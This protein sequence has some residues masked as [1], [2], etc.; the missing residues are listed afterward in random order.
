MR[1]V[2]I[3]KP[4]GPEVLQVQELPMPVPKP[5]EVRV[6]VMA[7]AVNRLDLLQRMG[8]YPVPKDDPQDIPGVEY[9]GVVDALGDGVGDV[10]IG[11]RVFGLVG[12]G[13]YAEYLVVA[14][15]L[16]ARIP[17]GVSFEQAASMPEAFIT[18]YD[19]M[20]SQ[21]G[22]QAG[23][24][25]LISAVGSGV[26]TAAVQI[27]QALGAT[28]IGTARSASK[29][30]AAKQYG[31]GKGIVV[32]SGKFA[33][34]VLAATAG[35][36]V[37]VVLE[38]VGGDYV[39]EDIACLAYQGRLILVG[40]VAG[41]KTEVDLAMLLR[42]RLN[43]RGTVLRSRPTAEKLDVMQTFSREM[44]P[45]IAKGAVQPV[46]DCVFQLEQAAAAHEYMAANENF[47]KVVLKVT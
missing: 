27:A 12:G 29:L 15:N 11:E 40:L 22:L 45:L 4:G 41:G 17:V 34:A 13:A 39:A 8:K 23:E 2:V 26:G 16:I 5:G 47:G 21:G 25:V 31:L 30:E 28:N 1:A 9:A 32:E 42:K 7:T 18:A 20:V 43:I 19:A 37:N 35:N 46:V 3:T 24:T 36:G 6:K 10:E 33:E 38:L 14:A 44:V